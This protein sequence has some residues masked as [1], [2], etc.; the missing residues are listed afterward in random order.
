MRE[1]P[2]NKEAM[3]PAGDMHADGRV[4]FD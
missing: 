1:E 2:G 4:K 3:A